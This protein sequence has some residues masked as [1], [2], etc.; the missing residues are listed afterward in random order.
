MSN[1]NPNQDWPAWATVCLTAC[2]VLLIPAITWLWR[3]LTGSFSRAEMIAYLKTRDEHAAHVEK[4]QTD[5]HEE[6]QEIMGGIRK[7]LGGTREWV[8][9]IDG[10]LESLE[11][12]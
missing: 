7:E 5:R 4:V 10:R 11:R 3:K 12:R 1:P 9:N 6:N 8:A 2:S